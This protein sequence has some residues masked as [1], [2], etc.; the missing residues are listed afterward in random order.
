MIANFDTKLESLPPLRE[1]IAAFGLDAQKSLGQNFLLDQ[2]ITDKIVR[3][4]GD[5]SNLHIIEIG[6]GPGGLTRS[7]LR[8]NAKKITAIEFDRR[9]VEALSSLQSIS[10]GRLEIVHGDA[11]STDIISLSMKPRAVVAN[12][13]YNIA[14]PLLI[15]WLREIRNDKDSY[16]F[17]TL[18][19]QKEVAQRMCAMPSSKVYGRLSV[20]TQWLCSGKILFDL[21]ARAFT[22]SPKVTSSVIRLI[23]REIG[24]DEPPFDIIEKI[25]GAAFQQRRKMIRSSLSEYVHLLGPLGIEPSLRAENLKINDYIN[26]GKSLYEEYNS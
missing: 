15:K 9:A 12:L 24:P 22:P 2:N 19:F 14:T 6:P 16:Q 26:L 17:M 18:M 20:V 7:L 23:P 11:L 4:C 10:E 8:Y 3:Q 25:T 1:I 21:P 5:I 13:P